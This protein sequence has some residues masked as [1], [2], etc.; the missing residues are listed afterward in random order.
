MSIVQEGFRQSDNNYDWLGPGAYFWQDAP[1][2]AL[3]WAKKHHSSSPAV[4][5]SLIRFEK[6]QAM[7]LLDIEWFDTLQEGYPLFVQQYRRR[8]FSLP[9]Q[10]PRMSKKHVLDHAFLKYAS[11]YFQKS[12]SRKISI[13]RAAFTEGVPIFETSAIYNRSH[14]QI[15]VRDLTCIKEST[16]FTDWS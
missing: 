12:G 10:D 3:D 11:S 6:E 1:N 2:R 5:R 16:I 8:D 14:V 15:A 9:T 13:I 7:D 4:V